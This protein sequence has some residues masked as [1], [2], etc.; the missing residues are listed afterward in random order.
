[1][2][3]SLA[4]LLVTVGVGCGTGE[5]KSKPLTKEGYQQGIQEIVLGSQYAGQLFGDLVTG[6]RPQSE[7]AQKAQAFHRESERILSEVEALSPPED[8]ADLQDEFVDAARDS[9]DKIGEAAD[10][11]EAGKLACGEP[12]NRAIYGLASTERAERALKQIQSK[13]YFIFGE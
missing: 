13:G 6:A 11:V 9:V 10:N 4:L 1:M 12:L 8:V 3:L 5:Q 2:R 7:C